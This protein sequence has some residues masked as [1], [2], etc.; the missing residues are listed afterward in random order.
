MKPKM[1]MVITI[2]LV[3]AVLFGSLYGSSPAASAANPTTGVSPKSD[4]LPEDVL[5]SSA[6]DCLQKAQYKEAR[7]QFEQF[8]WK[9]R[10]DQRL[11]EAMFYQGLCNLKLGQEVQA[12]SAWDQ[13]LKQEMLENTKSKTLLLTLEQLA[14]YYERKGK[15]AEKKKALNQLLV[16]FPDHE[17]TVRLH[18]QA[19]EAKL[20]ESD[21]AGARALYEKVRTNL[22]PEDQKN[23]DLAVIMSSGVARDPKQLL[24]YANR[25]FEGN[26]VDQAIKLYHILLKECSGSPLTAE[27]KTKLGWCHYLQQEYAEAEPLWQDVIEKGTI[28]DKWVGESRWHLIQL[29]TGPRNKPDK[30][31]ELCDVQAREFA[32]AFRGQQ[33][34]FIKAWIYWTMKDWAKAHPAFMDLVSAY[35]E[36]AQH[37]PIQDYIRDCEE[38]IRKHGGGRK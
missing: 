17:L 38:G 18:V 1:A 11:K 12:L 36:T 23:L 8:N 6:Q 5:W 3:G 9:Y 13:V 16:D 15:D 21:Y 27:A 4:V 31:I 10:T 30:A 32:G 28:K 37:K 35:P 7:Q 22:S 33:A 25:S 20:K 34:V 19:A 14:G 2:F 29:L 26:N 24:D